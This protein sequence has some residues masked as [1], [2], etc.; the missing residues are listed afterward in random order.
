M[1]SRKELLAAFAKM[2]TEREVVINSIRAIPADKLVTKPQQDQWSVTEI[3]LHLVKAEEGALKYMQIK[4]KHGGHKKATIGASI[5]HRL[6]NTAIAPNVIKLD[7][8]GSTSFAQAVEQWAAIRNQLKN[9]YESIDEEII[10]H[11]LFK[12]PAAG[13]L[14]IMQ[15][16]KFMR[17]HMNRHIGQ[18]NRTIKQVG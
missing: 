7:E 9:E 17:R 13:K 8:S 15:S 10:D 3:I 16:V 6:L 14:S 1:A 11:E 18:I 5:K 12:H 4:L 2:E